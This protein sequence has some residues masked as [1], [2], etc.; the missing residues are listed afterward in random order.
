MF[1]LAETVLKYFFFHLTSIFDPIYFTLFFSFLKQILSIQKKRTRRRKKD[2]Q[3]GASLP[4]DSK[5][6]IHVSQ[7][8]WTNDS[9]CIYEIATVLFFILILF[10]CK[11]VHVI[12]LQ[13]T[14]IALLKKVDKR[15]SNNRFLYIHRT[16][17]LL[18]I[19]KFWD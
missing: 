6:S 5:C 16:F 18:F 8:I 11:N 7:H 17:F 10:C 9:I 2:G 15:F 4:S 13:V 1:F 14:E 3:T 19:L 12:L